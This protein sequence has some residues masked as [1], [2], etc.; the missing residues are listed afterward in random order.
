M[1]NR[2]ARP[3]EPQSKSKMPGFVRLR[4]YLCR[5]CGRKFRD[6]YRHPSNRRCS[7]CERSV[8]DASH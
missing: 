8:T 1:E 4:N 7:Q 3:E 6:Y 2:T 5:G